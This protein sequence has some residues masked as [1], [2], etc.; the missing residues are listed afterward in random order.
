MNSKSLVAIDDLGKQE[1]LDILARA[2]YFEAHPNSKLLDGKVVATL[3]FEP[4]T[5]TR[6]SFETAVNR[7]GGRVIGFSDA[8]TSSTS[9]GE[10]LKDTIKMVSNYA[11]IIVMRHFLEG[12]AQYATEV[13]EV[14]IVNAGDGANQHPSQT[15]LDL[16][17]ILKTQGTL[18]GLTIT[19]VGDL[20]YGRTVHSL[21]MALRHFKPVFNF[22]SSEALQMPPGYLEIC[23]REG[24]EY[25]I[26]RDFS[27]EVINES[28]IIYMTRVQRER[29]S[30]VMEYEKVKNLYT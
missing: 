2:A 26:H 30:D 3:F 15:L 23:H 28:D 14:P 16:Y 11:D 20:K 24:I 12:A 19:M 29:F 9:K 25:H 1:L 4:S 6:L 21:L 5:R 13:T 10:T 17:S 18:E 7:L 27:P 22:V 8:S